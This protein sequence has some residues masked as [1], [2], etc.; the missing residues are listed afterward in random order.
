MKRTKIFNRRL[1]CRSALAQ[2]SGG[3]AGVSGHRSGG[4]YPSETVGGAC[5]YILCFK[6]KGTIARQE[7]ELPL[8]AETFRQ[9]EELLPAPMIRKTY[10]V[11]ALPD[12][13]RLEVSLVDAGTPLA[14]YYAEVEFD[15]LEQARAFVPPACL[16]PRRNGGAGLVDGR[17]L[18]KKPE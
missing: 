12:G 11:Y 13:R 6:G 1:P 4:A 8:S 14:F 7:I 5:T 9:L 2:G 10:K 3:G 17:V 15:T 18:G 16:G